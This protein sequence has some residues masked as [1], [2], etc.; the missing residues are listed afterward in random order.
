MQ[1]L[2][3]LLSCNKQT[4]AKEWRTRGD[5]AY[6]CGVSPATVTDQ[7]FTDR[8]LKE[9]LPGEAAPRKAHPCKWNMSSILTEQQE[10]PAQTESDREWAGIRME[11]VRLQ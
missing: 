7:M 5:F 10:Y 8:V 6:A 2:P 1:V 4:D 3:N 11:I 9:L